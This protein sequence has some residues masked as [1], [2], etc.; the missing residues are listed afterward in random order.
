MRPAL[1]DPR[2]TGVFHPVFLKR[3][4]QKAQRQGPRKPRLPGKVFTV[5]I[6]LFGMKRKTLQLIFH[7]I[8]KI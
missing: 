2:H 6:N 4:K 5:N 7:G 8:T 3:R 1:C